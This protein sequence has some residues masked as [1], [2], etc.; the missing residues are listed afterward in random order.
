[1]LNELAPDSLPRLLRRCALTGVL[2]DVVGFVIA[3]FI[4]PFWG[5]FGFAVGTGLA[6][7]NMRFLAHQVLSIEVVEGSTTK[8]VRRRLRT[9][10]LT[11][12]ATATAV[13]VVALWISG[14]LGM[15]IVSGL[16]V[17]Q[18]VFVANVFRTVATQGG[19]E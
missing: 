7:A 17:Y 10:A 3:T 9:K 14:P 16:V 11:R 12:L 2:V 5:A 15:G 18:V 8:Q 19:I 6:L 1:V 4:A 13:V